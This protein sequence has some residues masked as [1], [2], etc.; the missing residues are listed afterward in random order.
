MALVSLDTG[1]CFKVLVGILYKL[2][3]RFGLNKMQFVE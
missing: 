3:K 2:L 1:Q